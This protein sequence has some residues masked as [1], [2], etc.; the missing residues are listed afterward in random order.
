MGWRNEMYEAPLL[1]LSL[2]GKMHTLLSGLI[3]S[4]WAQFIQEGAAHLINLLSTQSSLRNQLPTSAL[5]SACTL[6]INCI[7]AIFMN[8]DSACSMHSKGSYLGV[9]GAPG[10]APEIRY[11]VLWL[12]GDL[13]FLGP[14]GFPQE[15][16]G[17]G[18]TQATEQRGP[19][20]VAAPRP[21]QDQCQTHTLFAS[22][23][24]STKLYASPASLVS[25]NIYF[26]LFP[27]ALL[28]F[29]LNTYWLHG[30]LGSLFLWVVKSCFSKG[31]AIIFSQKILETQHCN[32]YASFK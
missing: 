16:S 21:G 14:T 32:N 18:R 11:R 24:G 3:F 25:T 17:R 2:F 22:T 13:F 23:M 6:P 26:G 9:Q 8:Q 28:I 5:E 15:H 31:K 20:W 1:D 30:F 29:G 19:L 27:K 10:K 7:G 4:V 12:K